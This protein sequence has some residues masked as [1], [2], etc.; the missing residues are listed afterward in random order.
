MGDRDC[1]AYLT[2]MSVPHRESIEPVCSDRAVFARSLS[3]ID[4]LLTNRQS[5]ISLVRGRARQRGA[6]DSSQAT[7]VD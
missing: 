2:A 3:I 1:P 5:A 6:R 4:I 7:W